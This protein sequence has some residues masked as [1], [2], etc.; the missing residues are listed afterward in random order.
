[1]LFPLLFIHFVAVSGGIMTVFN[2]VN[3]IPGLL[4]SKIDLLYQ[5]FLSSFMKSKVVLQLIISLSILINFFNK[6][7]T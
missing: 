7:Q 6:N 4:K 2:Y 5:T 1:M 3:V